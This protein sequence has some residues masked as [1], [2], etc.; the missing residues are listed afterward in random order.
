MP[1]D[2]EFKTHNFSRFHELKITILLKFEV[3]FFTV[4]E[5]QKYSSRRTSSLGKRVVNMI[6]SGMYMLAEIIDSF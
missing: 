6:G 4:R 3:L 5:S 1:Y 2:C